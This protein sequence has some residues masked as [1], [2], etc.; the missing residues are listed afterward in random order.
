MTFKAYKLAKRPDG[1]F[2]DDCFEAVELEIPEIQDGQFLVKQS[3]MSLDPAMRTWVQDNEE[4][5]I[6]PVNPGDIMRSYGVGEVVESKNPDYPVGARV[7]GVT[8]WAEYTLGG[9]DMQIVDKSVDVGALLSALYVPGL[10]AYV[11]LMK[12]GRPAKGETMVVTGAA[13]SVGSLVGQIGKAEGLKVIGV[14]GSNEKCR[15]LEDELGFDKAINYKDADL[16]E[17]LVA[18]TPDGIDLYF[19]N[20]GG[21]IQLMAFNRMNRLGKMVVCGNIAEYDNAEPTPGPSW[22]DI[23]LKALR[24]EG[25]VITDH[26]DKAEES[27]AAMMGYLQKGQIKFRSHVLKGLDSA[28]EGV[29]ML[30]SGQ[31]KGKLY[32]EL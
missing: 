1:P 7:V 30:F 9:E 8:G 14:A 11:G 16:E 15:C 3:H 2:T 13:G 32:V 22:V 28:V 20:T 17:Q 26:Y 27:T 25:F 23:N 18:A 24:V 31:N 29:Q 12:I 6:E 4:S 19:E 10:T 5:Y 21:P